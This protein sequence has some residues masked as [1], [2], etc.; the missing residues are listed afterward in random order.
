M[1]YRNFIGKYKK[2]RRSLTFSNRL[3]K[4]L[5]EQSAVRRDYILD[6]AS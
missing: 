5:T 6:P 4:D 1:F 3:G 2:V